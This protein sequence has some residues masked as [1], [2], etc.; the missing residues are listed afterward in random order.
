MKHHYLIFTSLILLLLTACAPST[1]PTAP[2]QTAAP[3]PTKTLPPPTATRTQTATPAPPITESAPTPKVSPTPQWIRQLCSPL[4]EQTLAEIPEIVS[5]PYNPPPPGRDERHHGVDFAYYHRKNRTTNEGE[6][7]QALLPGQVIA[8]VIDQLP[9]GNMVIIETEGS[10]L[11]A[12]LRTD[13]GMAPGESLYHLYAHFGDAP[14]VSIGDEIACGQALGTVGASGYNIINPHLHLETRLGPA[15]QQ[16]PAGM[17]FYTTAASEA[18]REN[19]QLWR[20]SGV[21]RH[22]DPMRII[23]FYLES[24]E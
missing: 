13:L 19:Y 9:Y 21:F 8:T 17:G 23:R 20:T 24:R 4:A 15:G 7:V 18:E 16:F 5:D 2:S 6:I 11:P 12:E 22:F 10:R 14:L 1:T 3:V